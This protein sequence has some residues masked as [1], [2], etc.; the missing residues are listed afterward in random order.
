MCTTE[1]E[2]G[3]QI[4]LREH[5]RDCLNTAPHDWPELTCITD[6]TINSQCCLGQMPVA[7]ADEAKV[8]GRAGERGYKSRTFAQRARRFEKW[9]RFGNLAVQ[10]Q[11]KAG[12]A[13]PL[14]IMVGSGGGDTE[15]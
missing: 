12:R 2:Y 9:S 1:R 8:E 11:Q 15:R 4:L 6:D 10:P 3:V 14:H 13:K 5:A 7:H